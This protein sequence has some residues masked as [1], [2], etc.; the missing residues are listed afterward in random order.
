MVTTTPNGIATD[1]HNRATLSGITWEMYE[2]ILEQTERSGRR[3]VLNYDGGELEIEM[4]SKL[5]ELIKK[6]L[7]AILEVYL[8]DKA[9]RFV[10]AGQTTFRRRML[11][12]GLEADECYYLTRLD[13]ADD[14]TSPG[15]AE[16]PAPDL[17]VEVEVA[18]PL[19]AKLPIYAAVG[20]TEIWHVEVKNGQVR[21]RIMRLI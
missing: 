15:D 10:P 17:A 8:F 11:D 2:Q 12:K 7:A 16:P 6:F 9:T 20:V 1:P 21:C 19:L 4:P 14:T 5:H 13:E 18:T 3:C